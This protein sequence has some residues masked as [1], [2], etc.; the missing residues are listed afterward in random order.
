MSKVRFEIKNGVLT[1]VQCDRDVTRVVIPDG[2]EII[3]SYAFLFC[4]S[5]QEIQLPDSL[6]A[7]KS[8]AFGFWDQLK[9]VLLPESVEISPRAFDN[10]RN[11]QE[12][13][14]LPGKTLAENLIVECRT[15]AK[16][17][18][19]SPDC[20][21]LIAVDSLILSRDGKTLY[22]CDRYAEG[23]VRVPDGV[24]T[25]ARDAFMRCEKITRIFFPDS[26]RSIESGAVMYCSS[27]REVRLPKK[28]EYL[29]RYMFRDCYDLRSII[30][31]EGISL[32]SY[33]LFM[34]CENLR[35]VQFP[36]T[37]KIV[38]DAFSGCRNLEELVFPASVRV[39]RTGCLSEFHARRVVF[40]GPV[41]AM[42]PDD[43]ELKQN[44]ELVLD[45][46]PFQQLKPERKWNVAL[47]VLR[48]L[49]T[50]EEIGEETLR[51]ACSW[52]RENVE[53]VWEIQDLRIPLLQAGLISADAYDGILNS[54]LKEEKR[55]PEVIAML[56]EYPERFF[57]P[58]EREKRMTER[59]AL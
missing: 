58:E 18:T 25:V 7:I 57:T 44:A 55:D 50:G 32:L 15:K 10:C 1:K 23:T 45:W 29:G 53:R 22:H 54:T 27:L 40:Q 4:S 33:A 19:V 51:D 36:S 52:I 43:L 8:E 11:L 31:P 34:D 17:L 5:P 37:L 16:S 59:F 9:R 24:E 3:E 49:K 21:H 46:F 35:T 6:R 48:R 14:F 28:M 13:H 42:D 26:L 12:I 41:L 39:F 20:R 56:L 30:L 38:E 47:G 2:V